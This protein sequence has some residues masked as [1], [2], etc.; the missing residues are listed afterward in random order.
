MEPVEWIYLIVMLVVLIATVA[1]M[2]KPK[3]QTPPALGDFQVPTAEDGRDVSMI[4]GTVWIDDPNILNYGA[5]TTRP[6]HAT[7]GK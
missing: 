6:I 1:L 5:L 3:S 4:F 2:P 7:G